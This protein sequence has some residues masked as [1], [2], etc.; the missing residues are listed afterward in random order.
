[1][2]Q[3]MTSRWFTFLVVV[4]LSWN[5]QALDFDTT[6]TLDEQ[7]TIDGDLQNLCRFNYRHSF[8]EKEVIEDRL[9]II[10]GISE[11]NC[12]ALKAYVRNRIQLIVGGYAD[13]SVAVQGVDAI[14][15]GFEPIPT[16]PELFANVQAVNLG[17]LLSRVRAKWSEIEGLQGVGFSF[18]YATLQGEGRAVPIRE[19]TSIVLVNDL[20][21]LSPYHPTPEREFS[22]A[23]SLYRVSIL[24]GQI[25]FADDGGRWKNT[26]C[27]QNGVYRGSVLCESEPNGPHSLAA[28]FLLYMRAVCD[29]DNLCTPTESSRLNNLIFDLVERINYA[30]RGGSDIFSRLR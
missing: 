30:D 18:D 15:Q 2:I 11:V 6:V 22:V 7:T 26:E 28:Y 8:A 21:F 23:N 25:R 20:F 4:G 14:A 29:M 1:M 12:D 19:D 27:G 3:G 24:L 17:A 9:R 13:K 16:E 10:L 5:S